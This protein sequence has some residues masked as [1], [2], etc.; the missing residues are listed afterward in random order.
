[1]TV[2]E[3]TIS[4]SASDNRPIRLH[5][6]KGSAPSRGTVQIAHGMGEH[7]L[8]YRPIAH[9]LVEAMPF[10]P[11]TTAVTANSLRRPTN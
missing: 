6:W 9:A 8:R 10:T 4:I 1:M 3:S 11:A 7:A 2:D 5:C